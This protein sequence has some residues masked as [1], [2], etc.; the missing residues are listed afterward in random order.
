M[1]LYIIALIALAGCCFFAGCYEDTGTV[2]KYD[3]PNT[4]SN[5]SMKILESIQVGIVR[6]YKVVDINNHKIIYVG[7][8]PQGHTAAVA[9]TEESIK[10]YNTNP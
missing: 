1:K 3:I 6:V 10:Q 8:D 5:P 7:M 4:A 2:K 9:V